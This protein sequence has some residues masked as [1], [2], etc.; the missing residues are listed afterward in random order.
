M[1]DPIL[2][3]DARRLKKKNSYKEHYKAK[4]L[5]GKFLI[6]IIYQIISFVEG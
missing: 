6:W 2:F 1:H 4:R 5:I 3:L